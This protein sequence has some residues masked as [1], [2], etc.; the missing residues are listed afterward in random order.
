MCENDLSNVFLIIS[1]SALP[2]NG[3]LQKDRE[4]DWLEPTTESRCHTC[5]EVE[6]GGTFAGSSSAA[7]HI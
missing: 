2:L 5:N 7:D 4:L 1:L 6:T 3:S